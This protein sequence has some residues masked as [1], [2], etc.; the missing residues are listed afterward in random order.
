MQNKLLNYTHH[1]EFELSGITLNDLKDKMKKNKIIY[2]HSSDQ[3]EDKWNSSRTLE[4]A[5][6]SKMPDYIKDNVKKYS[7]WLEI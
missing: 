4:K 7:E 6:L 1:H 3:R 5:S 2:D